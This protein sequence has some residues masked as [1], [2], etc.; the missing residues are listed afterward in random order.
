MLVHTKV[1][2]LNTCV[3]LR[4]LSCNKLPTHIHLGEKRLMY[5]TSERFFTQH[6]PSKPITHLSKSDET[7]RHPS[8]QVTNRHQF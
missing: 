2:L 8:V 6:L 1:K 7:G 4:T 5:P 3:H